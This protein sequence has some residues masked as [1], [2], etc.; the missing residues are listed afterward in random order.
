MKTAFLL[1][2][3]LVTFTSLPLK[4]QQADA[5]AQQS[6]SVQAAGAQ[7][8]ESGNAGASVSGEDASTQASGS[9]TIKSSAAEMKPVNAELVGKLDTKSAKTGDQVVLKTQESMKTADGTVIPKGTRLV[10]HVTQVQAHDKTSAD[11]QMAIQFD[12]AELKNGQ[13]LAIQSEIR[14]VAPPASAAMAE[15]MQ[16][17]DS[18]GGGPV[19]GGV[20][21]TGGAS[22]R[23]GGGLVG[24]GGTVG[25]VANTTGRTAAGAG[26]VAD[27]SVRTTGRV[28]GDAAGDVDRNGRLAASGAG[29]FSARATG[30][31]GVMLAGDA[32]GRASG[33]LSASKQNVHLDGG[34]Q[35]V[36]GVS[37][38]K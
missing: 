8:N 24:G 20:R 3:A 25:A 1:A 17:E 38:A 7:V 33:M 11:S 2:T 6:T 23:S 28:A 14:S 16:S 18:F 13:G 12:R 27:D 22:A 26:S 31:H 21:T 34:T 29:G 32:S 4:A 36:L 35:M 10:G 5:S 19:G 9:S 37:A 30:V 15:S